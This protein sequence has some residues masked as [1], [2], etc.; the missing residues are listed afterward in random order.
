MRLSANFNTMLS[1]GILGVNRTSQNIMKSSG[2]GSPFQ[3]DRVSISPQ[4]KAAS[5]IDNL[6]KQKMAIE[7]RKNS[8]MSSALD[9]GQSMD[10]IQA[11][12][13]SYDEQIKEIDKQINE[14]SAK[15]MQE[16]NYD[17]KGIIDKIN[18][19]PKTE[20][21]IQNQKIQNLMKL[22]IAMDSVATIDTVKTKI[23]GNSAVLESEIKL[24]KM[25]SN[26]S[27]SGAISRKEEQLAD[28]KQ[29]S[30]ELAAD[31]G[32]QISDLS[33]EIQE[34]NKPTQKVEDAEVEKDS[35]ATNGSEEPNPKNSSAMQSKIRQYQYIQNMIQVQKTETPLIYAFA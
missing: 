20:Q 15:Q 10:S 25:R 13:D 30:M 14:I 17:K 9:A 31:I 34:N 27:A 18:D 29:Q 12:L 16:A 5:V 8:F 4:G 1:T 23:D 19:K 26:G 3:T 32:E 28:M 33:D 6:M 22:S 11:K 21:E 24:D 35:V 7:D 2:F